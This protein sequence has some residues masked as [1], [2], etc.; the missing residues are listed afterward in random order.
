MKSILNISTL[1]LATLI[2]WSCNS[3]PEEAT[4]ETTP[5]ADFI[6]VTQAQ[7]ELAGISYGPV[8]KQKS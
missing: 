1:F 7:Q 3:V 4:E 6:A 8:S 2:L 5:N